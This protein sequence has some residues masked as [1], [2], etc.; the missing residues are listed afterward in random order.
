MWVSK[1]WCSC[2]SMYLVFWGVGYV[3]GYGFSSCTYAGHLCLPALRFVRSD[4]CGLMDICS[5]GV[6]KKVVSCFER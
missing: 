3:C 6:K 2:N 5:A 4:I 1:C